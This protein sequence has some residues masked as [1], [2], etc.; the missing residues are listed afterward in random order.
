MNR[1]AAIGVLAL[2]AAAHAPKAHAQCQT[3]RL[4]AGDTT[5][6]N[7]K[8]GAALALSQDTLAIGAKG[9]KSGAFSSGA[10]YIYQH[11]GSAWP[12]QQRLAPNPIRSGMEFGASIAIDG[13]ACIVGSPMDHPGLASA[14]AAY[15]FRRSGS[16]WT[17]E[18][19]LLAPDPQ[20]GDQF[21]VSCA[22]SG[23]LAVVGVP[24]KSDISLQ[25]GC[26]YIYE[27]ID[28]VWSE[29]VRIDAHDGVDAAFFGSSVACAPG[30]VIIGAI[31][32][33][34]GNGGGQGAV[35]IYRKSGSNWVRDPRLTPADAAPGDSFGSFVSLSGSALLIGA[36]GVDAQAGTDQGAAYIYRAIGPNWT[37]E[38]KLFASNAAPGDLFGST[39]SISG[40]RALVGAYHAGD[41]QGTGY[42]YSRSGT[43]WPESA[44][45]FASDPAADSAFS[46]GAAI[47]GTAIALGAQFVDGPQS[48]SG[49][50]YLYS[51]AAC[52]CYPN[53]D[54]S[55]VAPAL[56][57]NDF[58]CFINALAVADPWA[59]CDGST[60]APSLNINDFQCFMNAFALGCS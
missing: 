10:A 49:A 25:A 21:A 42:L 11:S 39:G 32:K 14:G 2:A 48:N 52:T 55:T 38:S 13:D 30:L 3:A 16:T 50:A 20:I 56:N 58:S 44:R 43:L 60:A 40:D 7:E 53:C 41:S 33:F 19:R 23:N 9:A 29:G 22:I 54:G 31:N 34:T 12:F 17:Q 28:G 36:Y 59:N 27:R 4:I 37:L 1:K 47:D 6:A 5:I 8:Y 57:I 45:L 24:F 46:I 35:Y 51:T 26:A 18:A 15:I